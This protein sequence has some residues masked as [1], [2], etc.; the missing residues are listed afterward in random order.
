MEPWA[1]EKEEILEIGAAQIVFILSK[2]RKADPVVLCVGAMEG[3]FPW[4]PGHLMSSY[5]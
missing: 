1:R 5:R 3:A 4:E 2:N